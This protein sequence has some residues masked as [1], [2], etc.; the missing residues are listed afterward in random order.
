MDI[1]WILPSIT[2]EGKKVDVERLAQLINYGVKN[3]DAYNV[4]LGS[5]PEIT[6]LDR[7]LYTPITENPAWFTQNLSEGRKEFKKIL[8]EMYTHLKE[9]WADQLIEGLWSEPKKG[10]LKKDSDA[11]TFDQVNSDL[12]KEIYQLAHQ[13]GVQLYQKKNPKEIKKAYQEL[14]DRLESVIEDPNPTAPMRNLSDRMTLMNYSTRLGGFGEVKGS[15][16]QAIVEDLLRPTQVDP[17]IKEIRLEP[18]EAEPTGYGEAQVSSPVETIS[19]SGH[20]QIEENSLLDLLDHIPD[21]GEEKID[22]ISGED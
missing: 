11:L 15:K 3:E 19:E 21:P 2:R 1:P 20:A 13:L 22:L 14:R 7:V 17:S 6:F 16:D 9:D 5:R 18:V 4:V 10:E 12:V 8:L